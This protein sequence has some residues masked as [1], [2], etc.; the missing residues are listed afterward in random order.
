MTNEE[1]HTEQ[2]EP[3]TGAG[4]EASADPEAGAET[5]ESFEKLLEESEQNY[6]RPRSG[7]SQKATVVGISGD[8]VFID[9]GGKRE[10][11]IA[12]SEFHDEEGVPQ[13]KE[14]DEVNA[15]YVR[16][17][18]GLKYFTTL[19]HGY[20]PKQLSA[21]RDAFE[22]G[23]PVEGEV[24]R[25]IKGGFE[26]SV[27]GV[28]C[29]CP[30]SHIDLRSGREGG[31]FLGQTFPFKVLEYKEEGRNIIVSRRVLLKEEREAKLKEVREMLEVGMEVSGPVKSV[32]NF[33]AF[34]ELFGVVD[35]LIPV[36]EMGWGRIRKPKDVVS[37]GEVVRAKVIGLDW[38]RNRLT[39]SMKALQPDPWDSVAEKYPVD[40]KV[41]GTIVRLESFGAFVNLEPGVDG[42][43]H[44]S[45]L[46][47]DRHINH[48]KEVV[49]TGQWVDAYVRAV[50]P[51]KRKI[52]L[53][54]QPRFRPESIPLPAVGELLD[55]T[56][57]KI[58]PYGIFVK[59]ESGLTGL[60]PN[61][62]MGTP[63]GS[64]H[65]KMFEPGEPMQVTVIEV[66]KLHHRVRL[67]RKAVDKQK[68]RIEYDRYK[69]AADRDEAAGSGIGSLGQLLKA[70][71][72]ESGAVTNKQ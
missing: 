67:S 57:E 30:F 54:L 44:I 61:A 71:L 35:A 48:P 29:F 5:A 1:Q 10:G 64:D 68:E 26:V 27:G 23:L 16:S 72:E 70:K 56:V 60:V 41:G 6:V 17:S 37:V 38:E 34:V 8:L 50:D 62:E 36:S 2:T 53:S 63:R 25:E 24:R 42:L 55:G 14:G 58:M 33:G 59:L 39:L 22:A 45:N 12:I 47:A 28:R 46:G 32:Q 11:A 15:F 40:A 52:S 51:V 7:R 13:V 3:E 19:I 21:I 9:L 43:V 18:D 20:T 31:V 49:E 4:T 66:D 65:S 69:E